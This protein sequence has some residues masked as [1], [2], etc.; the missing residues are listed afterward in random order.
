MSICSILSNKYDLVE[1][2]PCI[3]KG[4]HKP[5]HKKQKKYE[6][7]VQK[8]NLIRTKC[9][10]IFSENY[11]TI[12]NNK[13]L[14]NDLITILKGKKTEEW[15]DDYEFLYSQV[16]HLENDKEL[17]ECYLDIQRCIQETKMYEEYYDYDDDYEFR[18]KCFKDQMRRSRGSRWSRW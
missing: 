4:K 6:A 17:Q 1:Y 7:K 2:N 9:H 15:N 14:Y 11:D 13:E 16:F 5:K 12:Y 3:R 10:K 8:T 18:Y